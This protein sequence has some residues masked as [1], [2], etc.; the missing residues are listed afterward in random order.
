MK[1]T[2]YKC[3]TCGE[4]S[5]DSEFKCKHSEGS[6]RYVEVNLFDLYARDK[7]EEIAMQAIWGS[8]G[9]N[10][11]EPVLY[12]RL[13]D[14]E[15]SHIEAILKTQKHMNLYYRAGFNYVLEQRRAGKIKEILK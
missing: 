9:I 3:K 8:R 10:G 6:K 13:I 5:K 4:I 11:D 1:I 12:R 15:T 2:Y 7:F 14:L